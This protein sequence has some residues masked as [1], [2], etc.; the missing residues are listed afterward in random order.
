MTLN[1]ETV[2][3]AK[4][5]EFLFGKLTGQGAFGLVPELGH[6]LGC[7]LLVVFIVN[8]HRV[9]SCLL[10]LS[11]CIFGR[12]VERLIPDGQDITVFLFSK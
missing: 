1:I 5:K 2:L 3:E 11:V 6:A 7:D 9:T 10:H 8:V 4:G 12:E